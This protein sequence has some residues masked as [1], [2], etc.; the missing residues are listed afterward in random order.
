MIDALYAIGETLAGQ[1]PDTRLVDITPSPA[2]YTLTFTIFFPETQETIAITRDLDMT[3]IHP[4]EYH[5]A[6]QYVPY[7]PMDRVKAE[8]LYQFLWN[9]LDGERKTYVRRGTNT[10]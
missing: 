7:Q 8:T 9:W 2:G 4:A 3:I 10:N 1:L 6:W 5:T